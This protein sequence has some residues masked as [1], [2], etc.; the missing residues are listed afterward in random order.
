MVSNN[1]IKDLPENL[2]L[3]TRITQNQTKIEIELMA[4]FPLGLI[5]EALKS[6]I[7]QC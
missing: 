7:K 5:S 4:G 2:G 1:K 3:L 6:E